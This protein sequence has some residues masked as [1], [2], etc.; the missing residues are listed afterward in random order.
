MV[1][2]GNRLYGGQCHTTRANG[3]MS[4]FKA[5]MPAVLHSNHDVEQYIGS[6]YVVMLDDG[7]LGPDWAV[8]TCNGNYGVM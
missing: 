1:G 7:Y 3:H 8:D 4:V 2:G 6:V 5:E